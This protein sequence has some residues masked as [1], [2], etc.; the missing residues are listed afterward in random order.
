VDPDADTQVV[1][2]AIPAKA[3]YVTLLRLALSAVSRL[4]P[5]SGEDVAELKLAVD[6]AARRWIPSAPETG[7]SPVAGGL[8]PVG[9]DAAE[10]LSA[11]YGLQVDRLLLELRCDGSE[12]LPASERELSLAILRATADE[13][14]AEPGRTRLVKYLTPGPGLQPVA[15]D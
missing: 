1:R 14:A 7:T 15:S 2:L 10:R 3:E 13:C 9:P 5:L 6:E 4:T 12:V 8:E 11:R